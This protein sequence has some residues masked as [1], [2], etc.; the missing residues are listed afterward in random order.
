M[1]KGL[2]TI[3]STKVNSL[4]EK[5]LQEM[6]LSDLQ[7]L[8]FLS[9][10]NDVWNAILWDA[11]RLTLPRNGHGNRVVITTHNH[12]VA[13]SVVDAKSYVHWLH[14]LSS[15]ESWA[16]FCKK[17]FTEGEPCPKEVKEVAQ[18]IVRKCKG[19]PCP[20]EV[21]EVAQEIVRK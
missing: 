3:P 7:E 13:S 18:E 17:A 15:K 20:K 10:F 2:M 21:K 16:L 11:I 1:A 6:F 8:K 12:G 4:S 19:E 14:L 9:V 5:Q